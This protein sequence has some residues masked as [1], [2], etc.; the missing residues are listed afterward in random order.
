MSASWD[1]VVV[2]SRCLRGA[3]PKAL[4]R[5][6]QPEAL[7]DEPVHGNFRLVTWTRGMC[8]HRTR[9]LVSDRGGRA[10]SGGSRPANLD[11][12]GRLNDCSSPRVPVTPIFCHMETIDK[13]AASIAEAAAPHADRHDIEGSFAAEGV[14]LARDLGYLAGPVPTDLGGSGALTQDMV[15]GQLI[16]AHGCGSTALACSMHLHVA[17]AA[18]WRWRRGD[19]IVEPLLRRVGSDRIVIASTGGNDWTKPTA[20]AVPVEGGWR[21]SGRKTFA[22]LS[23]AAHVA[24]TFAVIGKPEPGAD[25]IAFGLPLTSGGVRVEETWD[26][27]GMR[28]TGSHDIVVDDVF[29]SEAQVTGRRSWGELDRLLLITSLHAWPVIYATYLGVAQALLETVLRS[30]KVG[31]AAAR[32]VGLIDF[33]LRN[34]RWAL[35]A[36]LAELGDDPEPTLDNFLALQQMKRSVTMACQETA[37]GAA[38]LAGGGAYARRGAV[39]RMIRDLRASLYHPYPPEMTLVHAGLAR[40]GRD[41]DP[42]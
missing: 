36:V 21:V 26:A 27:A 32:Q 25:V 40:L 34:A 13:M 4:V 24:A 5:T 3:T 2:H 31:P 16:V 7:T 17:L 10:A 12:I 8:G 42:V 23:P 41:L 33:H 35:N 9:N 20:V 37:T 18:A 30:G 39:D 14:E 38:E 1:V 6:I 11:D 19:T 15:S 29:V 22:S 28:A